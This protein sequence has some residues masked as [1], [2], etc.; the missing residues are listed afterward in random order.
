V[1]LAAPGR[2][3]AEELGVAVGVAF[4]AYKASAAATSPGV[5]GETSLS[6]ENSECFVAV[7]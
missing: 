3:I 5:V 1:P 6:E 7:E 2:T 4:K